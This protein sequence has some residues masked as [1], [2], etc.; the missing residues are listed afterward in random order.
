LMSRW[1]IVKSVLSTPVL[2]I[3]RVFP[4]VSSA[5][6]LFVEEVREMVG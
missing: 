2:Y 6:R 3:W 5:Q 1:G 4:V